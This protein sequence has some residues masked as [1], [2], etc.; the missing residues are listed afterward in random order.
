MK[1]TIKWFGIIAIIAVIGFSFIACGNDDNGGDGTDPFNGTWISSELKCV[2]AN[3]SFKQ[4]RINDD[5]EVIRGTYTY[6][7]NKVTAKITE[8][9]TAMF[10]DADTWVTYANLSE[11][12]KGYV[13]GGTQQVTITNNTFTGNGMTFTKQ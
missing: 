6:S 2:A 10:G 1:N 3:G 12:Y 9:N 5:K 13:G 7:E 11:T 8:V 4:Y